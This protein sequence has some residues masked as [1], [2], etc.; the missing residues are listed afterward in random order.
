MS[1]IIN[2]W[3]PTLVIADGSNGPW[4][5]ERWEKSCTNA[6]VKFKTT[7]DGAIAISL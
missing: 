3:N 4:D 6:Q 1:R 2:Q 5:F 7:R